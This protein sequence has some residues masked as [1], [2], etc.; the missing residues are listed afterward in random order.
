MMLSL[1]LTM[2]T[3]FLIGTHLPWTLVGPQNQDRPHKPVHSSAQP[4]TSPSLP[5]VREPL[6]RRAPDELLKDIHTDIQFHQNRR[7]PLADIKTGPSRA[8]VDPW[9]VWVRWVSEDH[10]YP[11]ESFNSSE[12]N[13]ILHALATSPITEFG[14]GYKGTQLKATMMLGE[15]RTVFK[16]KR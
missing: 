8:T 13:S 15:Q 7:S 6:R 5:D 4:S 16:P 10:F 2:A 11:K 12:M 14:L 3:L 9:K 1:F